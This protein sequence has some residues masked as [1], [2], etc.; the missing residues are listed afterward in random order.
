M[1]QQEVV[2]YEREGRVARI[3]LNRPAVR[4]AIDPEMACRLV[5]AL[6]DFASDS[7][8]LVLI[9]TGAGSEAF[10]A[11]GDLEKTLPLLTGAREPQDPWDERIVAEPN[12]LVRA[13][14]RL[15]QLDKPVIA[16][17]NGFCLAG[18]MEMLLATDIRIAADHAT[19]GLPEVRLGL[20]PFAG[21]FARLPRQVSYCVAMEMLLTGDTFPAARAKELGLVNA[22]VPA[23][24]VLTKAEH[25]AAAIARNGA[26]AVREI[27]RTV[28]ASIGRTFEEAAELEDAARERVMASTDA[29]E[30]PAAFREKRAPRFTC[31]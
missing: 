16:A 6:D 15:P 4:N 14:L 25:V 21:T 10:C 2:L 8:L 19:F 31:T 27:K 5:D 12:I 28:V 3:T 1:P 9:L 11:G 30:G 24:G 22:V 13:A 17:V 20:I 29:R 7:K 18:G 23:A 26:R